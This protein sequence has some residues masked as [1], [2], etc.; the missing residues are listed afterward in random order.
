MNLKQ[1]IPQSKKLFKYVFVRLMFSSII[2]CL[3]L[4]GIYL[5]YGEILIAFIISIPLITATCLYTAMIVSRRTKDLVDVPL[6]KMLEYT[7]VLKDASV[8]LIETAKN[9]DQKACAMH[10]AADILDVVAETCGAMSPDCGKV[11]KKRNNS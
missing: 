3:L 9:L 8:A 5:S 11:T 6:S 10:T 1:K 2:S 7:R 4:L